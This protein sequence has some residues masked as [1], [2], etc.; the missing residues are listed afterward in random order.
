MGEPW[1]SYGAPF[2]CLGGL[3]FAVCGNF[4]PPCKVCLQPH[5]CFHGRFLFEHVFDI[6]HGVVAG[7]SPAGGGGAIIIACVV[8]SLWW[9]GTVGTV[10]IIVVTVLRASSA[11]APLASAAPLSTS[12]S[13][14][15]L[16]GGVG[17]R[18]MGA[19]ISG[20][21]APTSGRASTTTDRAV[22]HD[23]VAADRRLGDPRGCRA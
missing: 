3:A 13:P 14:R 20:L 9:G 2:G 5:T 23:P 18:G 7:G 8:V 1:G 22:L 21:G 17:R 16:W 6:F 4:R 10:V 19:P 12:F 11:A 15:G